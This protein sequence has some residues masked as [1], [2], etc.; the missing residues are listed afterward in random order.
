VV[1][2]GGTVL[3]LKLRPR[4]E[5]ASDL[6]REIQRWE[7][8]VDES[9]QDDWSH[10]GL[11][12]A[13]LVAGRDGDATAE[14]EQAVA[15]NAKNWVALYQLGLLTRDSDP[16]RAEGLLEDAARYAPRTSKSA[17]LVALGNMALGRG[18][19]EAA[20]SAFRRAVAD[21]P[22]LIDPHVGLARALEELGDE[23]GALE[24]YREAA[25]YDPNNRQVN[26]AI[27]RLE[28]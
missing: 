11:G 25:R 20:R 24:Q 19:A 5:P 1:G 16:I 7:E 14:F 18:D 10:A 6:Q 17:P 26:E 27:D 4:P 21:S 13:L 12:M 15:L 8:A 28:G 23:K 22:F 3:V 2:L 9:P